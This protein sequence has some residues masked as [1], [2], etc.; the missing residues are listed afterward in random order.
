MGRTIL[1]AVVLLVAA[2]APYLLHHS[3]KILQ[4]TT[5]EGDSGNLFTRLIGGKA[6]KDPVPLE[7][8]SS[9]ANGTA[10]SGPG[11]RHVRL[12]GPVGLSVADLL[13][14]DITKAWLQQNWKTV[15][16]DLPAHPLHGYRVPIMTGTQPYDVVGSLTYYFNEHHRIERITLHGFTS[17]YTALTTLVQQRFG[18]KQYASVGPATYLAFYGENPINFMQIQ[19]A[20]AP[21]AGAGPVT[22]FEI[23]LELNL[24]TQE[25]LLSAEKLQKLYEMQRADMI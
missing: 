15:T 8:K 12:T 22:R 7:P 24:P 4:P 9:D 19:V 16:T 6:N 25:A 23:E 21:T 14:F 13:R 11:M 17:D 18:L 5:A 3:S 2:S 20:P 1:F 10:L